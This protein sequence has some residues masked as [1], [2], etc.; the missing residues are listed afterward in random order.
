MLA[1]PGE[2]IF[3]VIRYFGTRK[4][5]FNVHFRN[6]RGH[7]NDFLEVYPDEGTSTAS[8][9]SRY[10]ERSAILICSCPIMFLLH[11]MTLTACNRSH[12]ATATFE[13]SSN[14]WIPSARPSRSPA[15]ERQETG[16]PTCRSRAVA[17]RF[18][19]LFEALTKRT[20]PRGSLPRKWQKR[21][22]QAFFRFR[23]HISAITRIPAKGVPGAYRLAARA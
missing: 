11:P 17:A 8:K 21:L 7:R 16:A 14:P 12:S 22:V 13:P 20:S 9:P 4:K 19:T 15:I 10:I 5:I 23:S 3:D 6:I 18:N 1:D 2:E